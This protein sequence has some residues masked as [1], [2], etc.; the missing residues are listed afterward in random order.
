MAYLLEEQ[1]SAGHCDE[2]DRGELSLVCMF[3]AALLLYVFVCAP[4]QYLNPLMEK[5]VSKSTSV[6]DEDSV[7]SFIKQTTVVGVLPVPHPIITRKYQP[8]Q[9]TALWFSTFMWGIIFLRNQGGCLHASLGIRLYQTNLSIVCCG[10]C[11][12]EVPVF[13]SQSIRLFT[14]TIVG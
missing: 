3:S 8:N 5:F 10:C 12:T 14:V 11:G 4:S 9:Y 2:A 1:A 7:V 6:P 13:D